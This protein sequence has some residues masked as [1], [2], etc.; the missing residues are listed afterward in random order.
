[1][2]LSLR[3]AIAE[4]DYI[5]RAA[6]RNPQEIKA[7]IKRCQDSIRLAKRRLCLAQTTLENREK[8]LKEAKIALEI[9]ERE[10]KK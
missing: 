8:M 10:Q 1:M 5:L 7:F 4:A 6:R 3:W 2:V 9:A